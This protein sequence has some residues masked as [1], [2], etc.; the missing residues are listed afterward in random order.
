MFEGE[1]FGFG[2]DPG[3]TDIFNYD[4]ADLDGYYDVEDQQPRNQMHKNEIREARLRGFM[5]NGRISFRHRG[6]NWNN[7]SVPH[8]FC[9]GILLIDNY[10]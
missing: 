9:A 3:A 7:N 10:L 4:P 5:A 2:R 6:T 1:G 8:A